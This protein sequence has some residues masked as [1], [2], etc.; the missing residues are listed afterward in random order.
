MLLPTCSQLCC[1]VP[2]ECQESLSGA[3][4]QHMT[5][6]L[7]NGALLTPAFRRRA[8]MKGGFF[9]VI[10][11]SRR[12]HRGDSNTYITHSLTGGYS[13]QYVYEEL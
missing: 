13:P 9:T 4:V 11:N 1:I 12:T 8:E 3:Y 6:L 10:A 2:K 5:Q 7:R